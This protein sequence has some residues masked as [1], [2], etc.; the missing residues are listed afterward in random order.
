MTQ[1]PSSPTSGL[2]FRQRS[3]MFPRIVTSVVMR[4]FLECIMT[5]QCR[6]LLFDQVRNHKINACD[7]H[8]HTSPTATV[9]LGFVTHTMQFQPAVE[10]PRLITSQE[11]HCKTFKRSFNFSLLKHYFAEHVLFLVSLEGLI[12]ISCCII[13]VATAGSPG[14]ALLDLSLPSSPRS[15]TNKGMHFALLYPLYHV[16]VNLR[17]S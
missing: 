5:T 2:L 17:A 11:S 1:E 7:S 8:H 9:I 10:N 6:P 16:H 14:P 15:P 3:C 13:C 12:I 4:C